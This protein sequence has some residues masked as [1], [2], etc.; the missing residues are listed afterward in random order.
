MVGSDLTEF[1]LK[2]MN[3]AHFPSGLN[4]TSMVLIESLPDLRPI[5]L[6]NVV[7]K[8]IAKLLANR[9]KDMCKDV[10]S[11]SQS[12]FVL[13]RLIT[14]NIMVAFAEKKE[15]WNGSASSIEA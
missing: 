15:I 13:D 3:N 4:L 10:L 11:K 12:A 6:C 1:C 5:S 8:A 2:C 9:M 14:D 7:Y